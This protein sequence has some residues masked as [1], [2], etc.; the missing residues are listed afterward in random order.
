MSEEMNPVS[1]RLVTSRYIH[2]LSWMFL[3]AAAAAAAGFWWTPWFYWAAGIF[4]ALFFWLLWLIPAQVRNMG[5]LETDDELLITRGKLWYTFTV[6]P[7]G[8]IQFVDVTSGPI[9]RAL[10]LKKLQLHTASAS[11]DATIKGLEAPLADALRTR[12]AHQARERMSGL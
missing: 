11:T 12:L 5:W 4:V 9:D 2:H 3:L 8:R 7:Y 1:Q 6:V 10:G